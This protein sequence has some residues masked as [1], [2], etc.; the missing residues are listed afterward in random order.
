MK[1]LMKLYLILSFIYSLEAS[2]FSEIQHKKISKTIEDMGLIQT[3]NVTRSFIN[4][5]NN[6]KIIPK[7]ITD[8]I[9]ARNKTYYNSMRNKIN[10]AIKSCGKTLYKKSYESIHYD[11]LRNCNITKLKIEVSKNFK[12]TFKAISGETS[13]GSD[14]SSINDYVN[15]LR[16]QSE[17]AHDY[18]IFDILFD[19]NC[20]TMVNINISKKR[21]K[22]LKENNQFFKEEE[23]NLY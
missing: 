13:Q 18:K 19:T 3:F 16:T 20:Q 11:L 22:E 12:K 4:C 15:N 8:E 9:A 14:Y 17:E 1:D 10:K 6:K 21:Y 7:T 23:S 2:I 5:L